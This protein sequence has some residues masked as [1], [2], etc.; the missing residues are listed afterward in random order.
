MALIYMQNKVCL[1]PKY[2][3]WTH[4]KETKINKY[5]LFCK[6]K[7]TGNKSSKNMKSLDFVLVCER[8]TVVK[9]VVIL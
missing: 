7:F 5:V 9:S 1:V 8:K 6:T 4:F 2:F 3:N